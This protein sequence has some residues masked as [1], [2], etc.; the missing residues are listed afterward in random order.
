MRLAPIALFTY[1]RPEHTRRTVEALVRNQ[2][3]AESDLI[4]FSDG[5]KSL[6][7]AESVEAV[8][9]FLESIHGFKSVQIIRQPHNLGL[10]RSIISGVTQVCGTHGRVI[11]LEDD[12][13]TSPWFLRFMNE[14]LTTYEND[15]DVISIHGYIYPV[16]TALPETFFLRG[17]DCWGWATW[18][19]AWKYF[20]PDGADLLCQLEQ[21]GLTHSFDLDD[22]YGYTA[23]LR[24]QIAGKNNSWAIRWHASAFLLGKLTLYPGRSL[25]QNIGLDNSGTHCVTTDE[26]TTAPAVDP[27]RIQ[28]LPLKEDRRTRAVVGKYLRGSNAVQRKP[29][30]RRLFV[31]AS[32]TILFIQSNAVFC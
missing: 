24:D 19:R 7:D 18:D 25:V 15:P 30:W 29:W 21:C 31:R 5:P 27:I 20:N 12:M 26:F 8:R 16:Q 13:L 2:F 9:Q 32:A 1:N 23:M 17:A 4:V 3:A 14:G 28:R 10:A 6:G 11:V 22:S